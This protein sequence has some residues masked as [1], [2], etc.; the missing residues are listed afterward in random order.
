[1]RSIGRL[2][3]VDRFNRAVVVF[4][5]YPARAGAVGLSSGALVQ[6]SIRRLRFAVFSTHPPD[7]FEGVCN[8]VAALVSPGIIGRRVDH[9]LRLARIAIALAPSERQSG[10]GASGAFREIEQIAVVFRRLVAAELQAVIA[11]KRTIERLAKLLELP[12]LANGLQVLVDLVQSGRTIQFAGR[13]P[14][15]AADRR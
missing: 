3:G 13:Q 9:A 7:S 11:A 8:A 12:N 5:D 2:A 4:S 10:A 6:G 1:M 15:E 14:R